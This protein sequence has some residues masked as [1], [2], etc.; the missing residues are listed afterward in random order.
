MKR[1]SHTYP[2]KILPTVIS[3]MWAYF[4][5]NYTFAEFKDRNTHGRNYGDE[6]KELWNE[7]YKKYLNQKKEEA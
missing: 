3:D 2:D 5:H 6:F 4:R 7:E 1:N